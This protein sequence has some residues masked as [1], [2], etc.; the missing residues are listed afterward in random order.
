M[1]PARYGML[2][3]ADRCVGCYNC[4]LACR[5]E[6]AGRDHRPLTAAQPECGANWIAVRQEERGSFPT[7]RV[8]YVPVPC[9]HCADAP[10]LKAAPDALYRRADGIVVI[11]PDKARGRSGIVSSCPYG[12]I[13]W[14]DESQVPQKCTFCA[15]LLDEGWKEPRCVEAC[16][17]QAL[18]FG[19]LEDPESPLAQR[20]AAR[21]LRQLPATCD[22]AP[23][24]VYAGL[25]SP[26]ISGEIAF[27][28]RMH[29][30]AEGVVVLLAFASRLIRVQ[31]DAF[32]DFEFAGIEAGA[33]CVVS[34]QHDGY[35]RREIRVCCETGC[36]LGTIVLDSMTR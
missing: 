13:V 12:V 32:G 22:T 21:E 28:D 19:D 11:D 10:C 16:P 23:A 27:G 35:C 20:R 3:E 30:P 25:P 29:E 8:G 26:S 36:H 33:A 14:N 17:T 34:V 1:S 18:V 9:L 31:T 5:D 2:I 24:V 6:H 7:V 15:H 4:Q